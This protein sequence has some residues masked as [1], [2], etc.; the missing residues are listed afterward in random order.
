MEKLSGRQTFEATATRGMLALPAAMLRIL[1]GQPVVRD[2]LTL[3]VQCQMLLKMMRMRGVSLGGTD[4]ATERRRMNAQSRTLE[5]R[6]Q[7]EL[8]VESLTVAGGAGSIPAR[9][10]T[11]ARCPTPAPAVVFYHGGGFVIGSLDSHDG[12]CRALAEQA[13]C[14][15]IAVD[16]RLAPEHPAPAASDDAIA[17]F[18]DIVVRA[19][20]LGIDAARVAVAGDSA[21]GNLAA[22]VSQQT[23]TDARPPCYQVLFYPAVDFADDK[24]SKDIFARGFLLEKASMDWFQAHYLADGFDD[25]DPRVSPL[26][27]DVADVAPALIITAGF[28]PLRDEGEAYAQKLEAAG[29]AVIHRRESGLIHGF[30]NFSGGVERG[31][32]ALDEAASDLRKAFR[33][34]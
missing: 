9:R 32:Q 20:E 25:R 18:R 30:L 17:A 15:V 5:P 21:G 19:D 12:I 14:V 13:Q 10:Y 26:Y 31:D 1:A 16:Y 8:R 11:P 34:D 2:G 7:H 22:V 28:D 33:I 24:P 29:V 4:V 27:G 6:A 23:L 3:D